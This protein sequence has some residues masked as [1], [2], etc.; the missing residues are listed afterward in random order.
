[1]ALT[2][3]EAAKI[4]QNEGKDV[5][6]AVISMFARASDILQVMPWKN[7]NGNAYGYNREG[8]LPGIAFRGVNQGYT[9]SEG[10]INPLTESLRICGGDLDVDTFLVRTLG[11][12][13][14]SAHEELKVKAL[15]AELTRVLIKGNS[16]SDPREF[17]GLQRR[18]AGAQLIA[19]GATDGGNAMSLGKL[20]EAVDA[21]ASPTHIIMSKAVRRLLTTASRSA[22]LSGFL[23]QSSD[24]FGRP[25]MMYNGLPILVPYSDNGGTEPIAFDEVGSTGSTATATSSPSSRP[26]SASPAAATT[27]A[28]SACSPS[29]SPSPPIAPPSPRQR[30]RSCVKNPNSP[31]STGCSPTAAVS[32]S[33]APSPSH[34]SPCPAPSCGC[35]PDTPRDSEN[36]VQR[37]TIRSRGRAPRAA[38]VGRGRSA[39][40][41]PR[42]PRH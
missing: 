8:V 17:D 32:N 2:L 16:E 12:Q 9:A 42:A 40:A 39:S 11:A 38:P 31:S 33:S 4:A 34:G 29:A 14:R 13:V 18:I 10:I 35:R 41:I 37:T 26:A 3:V 36:R 15:S 30:S 21:C 27:S 1:M 23:E 22:A 20:D 19:N 5:K 6:A 28:S 25:V 7:I 24:A